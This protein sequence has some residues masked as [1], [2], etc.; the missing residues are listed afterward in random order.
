MTLADIVLIVDDVTINWRYAYF[1]KNGCAIPKNSHFLPLQTNHMFQCWV[2]FDKIEIRSVLFDGRKYP[3]SGI[4]YLPATNPN[5]TQFGDLH[6]YKW[7]DDALRCLC[8]IA[9]S[10]S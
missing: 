4:L 10:I 2:I 8:P 6:V 9:L 3:F 7:H 1:N 5:V